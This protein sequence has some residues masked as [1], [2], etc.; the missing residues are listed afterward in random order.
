MLSNPGRLFRELLAGPKALVAPGAY[1]GISARLI[2]QA[3]F[4]AIYRTGGGTSATLLGQPDLGLTTMTEMVD[5]AARIVSS[6][7]VPVIADADTGF[8]NVLN[9]IRTVHEFERS[10]VAAIHLE[11]QIF[12]KRCAFMSGKEVV[13]KEEFIE[14]I[15]AAVSERMNDDFVIIART[16]ARGPEGLQKAIDR[17]K[18]YAEA[19]ADVLFFSGPE[20]MHDVEQ[21]A[22]QLSDTVPLMANMSA[23]SATPSLT[24]HELE[25]MGYK[26][27]IFPGM[28]MFV[29]ASAIQEALEFL[30]ERGTDEGAQGDRKLVGPLDF[31]RKLGLQD[32]MEIEKKYG[33]GV[34]AANR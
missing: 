3:G 22:I 4:K 17:C 30:K 34:G 8:G 25:Q 28:C 18:Y 26:F 31:Y 7:N 27:I 10:G 21:V 16:D 6:V 11:D 1:D 33:I 32:W 24:T 5:H 15:K 19:G 2:E 29:A 20:S 9:V 12:P 14:K 23:G 13:D